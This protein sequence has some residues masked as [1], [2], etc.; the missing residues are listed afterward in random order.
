MIWQGIKKLSGSANESPSA[1][2]PP[3]AEGRGAG[4]S[5]RLETL[6]LRLEADEDRAVNLTRLQEEL[7][8]WLASLDAFDVRGKE[9]GG[10]SRP[11][12]GSPARSARR[13]RCQ[14]A[15]LVYRQSMS[16]KGGRLR[17]GLLGLAVGAVA[18]VALAP[19]AGAAPTNDAFSAAEPL[20]SAIPATASGTN[21]E[22][23]KEAGEPDH[24]GDP[25]GH[26]RLVLVDADVDRAGADRHRLLWK[27]GCACSPRRLHRGSGECPRLGRQQRWFL[28]PGTCF[29]EGAQVEWDAVAGTICRIAA[30][31]AKGDARRLQLH[32]Q[33][34]PRQRRPLRRDHD[35]RLPAR[36]TCSGATRSQGAAAGEPQH[37]GQPGGRSPLVDNGRRKRAARWRSRP[38]RASSPR[39][40]ARRL[41]RSIGRRPDQVAAN[42][43]APA[44]M[45]FRAA[46]GP[47]AKPASMSGRHHLP[48]R[49]RQHRRDPRRFGLRLRGRPANDDFAGATT[50]LNPNLRSGLGAPTT[51]RPR[52]PASPAHAGSPGLAIRSGSRGRR[53][54][55]RSPP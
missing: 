35:L 37:A 18:L 5:N 54:Q 10:L 39:H 14:A 36:R 51:W 44:P 4:A 12:K 28:T 31:G 8:A 49:R 34:R 30:D 42:D 26:L 16:I 3:A 2:R 20:S 21:L 27:S 32:H 15:K 9:A 22:A 48:D 50:Q 43:D 1:T 33:R 17:R 7:D 55:P 19:A 38:A 46:P 29:G 11:E 52:R 25:G 47:T 23:T 45:A 24:A 40:P 13:S 41:H 6:R 53:T